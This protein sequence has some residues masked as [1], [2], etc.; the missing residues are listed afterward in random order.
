MVEGRKSIL[1]ASVRGG[2]EQERGG[3]L[4]GGGR[5]A[6]VSPRPPLPPP[7]QPPLSGLDSSSFVSRFTDATS[8]KK[9]V[10]F[11]EDSG[12][13]RG[14]GRY[15]A[16]APSSQQHWASVAGNN[17]WQEWKDPASSSHSVVTIKTEHSSNSHQLPNSQYSNSRRC[18]E[19]G[20]VA[21]EGEGLQYRSWP[22]A[23]KSSP[24]SQASSCQ[25][26]WCASCASV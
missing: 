16:A 21:A 15:V 25:C 2:Q 23:P 10:F 24:P 6:V 17:S 5:S 3:V 19:G 1:Y 4:V 9:K 12:N 22:K 18:T 14:S 7:R 8:N 13:G 20:A 11:E 26:G